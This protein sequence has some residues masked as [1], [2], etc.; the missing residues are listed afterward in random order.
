MVET[1]EQDGFLFT[2][3]DKINPVGIIDIALP[4]R[5][6]LGKGFRFQ[7]LC[8]NRLKHIPT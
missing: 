1:L 3:K 4:N 5:F 2:I 6:R 8:N 7:K